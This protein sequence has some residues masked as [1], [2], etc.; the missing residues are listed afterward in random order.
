MAG[1]N[2]ISPQSQPELAQ[3]FADL[4]Q[5][6]HAEVFGFEKL[7]GGPLDERV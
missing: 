6:R 5:G 3:L 7:V 1:R 2:L 4:S